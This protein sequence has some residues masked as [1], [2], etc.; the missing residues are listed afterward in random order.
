[1]STPCTSTR[2]GRCSR[3]TPPTTSIE[4][5]A[6]VTFADGTT[7]EYRFPDGEPVFGALREY[8]WR[9]FEGRLRLDRNRFLWEPTARWI[10]ERYDQPVDTVVLIRRWSETPEPGSGTDRVWQQFEFFTLEASV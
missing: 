2:A 9:K 1:M 5:Y 8:R 7:T 10:A 6:A 4:T 3:R